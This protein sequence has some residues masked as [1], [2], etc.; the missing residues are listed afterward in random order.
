MMDK[1][2]QMLG[3]GGGTMYRVLLVD[4]EIWS[5]EGIRKLLD[6][7]KMGFTVIAQVT[8]PSEAWNI[9]CSSKPDVVFTDIRMPEISGIELMNM[10]RK[11][12]STS[13]FIVISGY[14][15]FEYAQEALRYGAFDYQLKPIDPDEAKPL[16]ERL[17]KHL[18][19]KQLAGNIQIYEQL[20]SGMD[21]SLEILKTKGVFPCGEYWQI[22][23]IYGD[24]SGASGEAVSLLGQMNPIS[25]PVAAEKTVIV[26][27]GAMSLDQETLSEMDNWAARNSLRIGVSSVSDDAVFLPRLIRES[28]MAAVAGHFIRQRPGVNRYNSISSP[29]IERAVSKVEKWM[30]AKDYGEISCMMDHLGDV[31]KEQDLGMYHA[32]QLWN[33]FVLVISQRLDSGLSMESIDFMDYGD[34]VNRFRNL[35]EMV[36]FIRETFKK[37]CFSEDNG[38]AKQPQYNEHFVALLGYVN[39]NFCMELS[40]S[41][42]AEKFFLNMSYC[43]ELF[44]KVTGCT[45]T[46]YVT[47]LRMQMAVELLQGGIHTADQVCHMTGY[48]DYYYFSK[49]FK[50]FHGVPPSY[51]TGKM[52]KRLSPI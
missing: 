23:T 37:V 52:A 14:A 5:L 44:K 16:L 17:K 29:A 11:I 51:F 32:T 24:S 27:N 49:M 38:A 48:R 8:D 7:E 4:D 35:S 12:G 31:F 36:E 1:M 22:A 34:I 19:K 2:R 26:L 10:S 28:D 42:L 15:E 20:S 50:K 40:L 13:E 39:K 21:D 47:Q 6:W 30:R 25:L 3:Q 45:F 33:R 46:D 9:I 18:D 41:E 43:S